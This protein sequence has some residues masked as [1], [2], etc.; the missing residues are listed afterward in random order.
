MFYNFYYLN[1]GAEQVNK[2]VSDSLAHLHTGLDWGAN[3]L[4]L[5]GAEQVISLTRAI[6]CAGQITYYY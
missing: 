6:D 4:S 1:Q 2:S 3:R 5:M